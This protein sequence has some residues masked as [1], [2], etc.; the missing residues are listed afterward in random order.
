MQSTQVIN[1]A[2]EPFSVRA[3]SAM[4]LKLSQLLQRIEDDFQ[5]IFLFY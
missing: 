5:S 1:S 4:T 3:S 2:R